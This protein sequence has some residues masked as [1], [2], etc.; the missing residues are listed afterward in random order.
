MIYNI[1]SENLR[2]RTENAA[3]TAT[4]NQDRERTKVLENKI[5]KLETTIDALNRRMRDKDEYISQMEQDLNEK[6]H[7]INR[8]EH[9]KEKQRRKFDS[10]MA[11][12]TDKKKR[13]LENRLTEQKRK[14]EIHMRTQEEKLRLVT[15]IVN[16]SDFKTGPV[17]NL[18]HQFNS[19]CDGPSSERKSRPKVSSYEISQLFLVNKVFSVFKKNLDCNDESKT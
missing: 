15:D 11:H 16:G 10:K 14:L 8:K 4:L 5:I 1:E 17:S 9:E 2:L 3:V 18:I 19:H 6:Q 13:E 7:Q 12:E